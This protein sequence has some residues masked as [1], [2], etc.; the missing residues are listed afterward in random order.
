MKPLQGLKVIDFST[1]LPGPLASLILAEA[2]A[3]VVKLEKP[4]SGDEMRTYEPKWGEDSVNFALLNRGKK[5]L[6][7]DL[8]DPDARAGLLSLIGEA[9]VLVEQFRPGVMAR[10]GLD[11]ETLAAHF[12]RLIY[13]SITGYGQDGPKK[14]R[15][16]H[17]L[18]YIAETGLLAL[19]MG[20][21]ERV[22]PPALIAD[23]AG[24]TY[25]AVINILL[26]LLQRERTGNGCHLDI[27][28]TES[29]FT[30]MYWAI[31][32]GHT[33]CWPQNG[34]DLVTGGTPRYRLYDTQDGETVAVAAIEDKFWGNF[35][36]AIGLEQALRDDDRDPVATA[37]AVRSKIAAKPGRHWR[38]V[39]DE[40][41]CCCSVVIGL[42]EALA[43]SH[44]A[45]RGLFSRTVTNS[46]GQTMPALPVPLDRAF[47]G[48]ARPAAAPGLGA[49]NAESLDEGA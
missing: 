35:C 43:D 14:H 29:L 27:A 15:A 37:D 47:L 31:G 26:A 22:L 18:N 17:D 44:V 41:E 6:A 25:P 32:N 12:P 30:L 48:V 23:I 40:V 49:H 10:L 5:S 45:A 4:E 1:L 13:C 36:D 11:Y 38:R 28:M 3:D 16:G 34:G 24:G 2:G 42:E 9:D 19:S 46:R 21:S 33:G 7:V 8:K 39:F 20:K